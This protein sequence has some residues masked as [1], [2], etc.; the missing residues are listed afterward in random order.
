MKVLR[1]TEYRIWRKVLCLTTPT[2]LSLCSIG[3]SLMKYDLQSIN[4][5]TCTREFVH[6]QSQTDWCVMVCGLMRWEAGDNRRCH[7]RTEN[8]AHQFCSPAKPSLNLW[9][10]HWTTPSV[11]QKRKY[12]SAAYCISMTVMLILKGAL[13]LRKNDYI[14]RGSMICPL[15]LILFQWLQ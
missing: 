13:H 14:A 5:N 15:H 3:V 4:G 9:N 1:V 12:P 11:Q 2:I 6:L 8:V 10:R 7:G